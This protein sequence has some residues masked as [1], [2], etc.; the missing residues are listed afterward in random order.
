ML[1]K[2]KAEKEKNIVGFAVQNPSFSI[3]RLA[4]KLKKDGISI[5]VGGIYNI[6][7]RH[8]LSRRYDRLLALE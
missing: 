7:K 1:N 8:E 4:N 2:T 5:S 3:H 6:L